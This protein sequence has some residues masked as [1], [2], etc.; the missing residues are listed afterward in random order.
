MVLDHMYVTAMK[1]AY[2]IKC[3]DIIC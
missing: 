2:F 3:V 1:S